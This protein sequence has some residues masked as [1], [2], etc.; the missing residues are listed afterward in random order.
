MAVREM[1]EEEIA[2]LRREIDA[3]PNGKVDHGV[4]EE[5]WRRVLEID[6]KMQSGEVGV[7]PA[8]EVFEEFRNRRLN[9]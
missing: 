6:R 8:E 5:Q 1:T 3:R 2:L 4:T 7:Q 9:D